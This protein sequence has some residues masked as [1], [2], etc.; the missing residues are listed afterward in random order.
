MWLAEAFNAKAFDYYPPLHK[1]RQYFEYNYSQPFSLSDAANIA[2]LETKHFG[3][4]FRRNVGMGFKAW[5]TA[6]RIEMAIEAMRKEHH[7]LTDIAFAVGF[8]EVR[9]F[10]RAFKKH[11]KMTPIDFRRIVISELT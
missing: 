3:K 11:T 2:G 9:T 1:V 8:Q 7:S 4:Y 6:V 10:E 5:T